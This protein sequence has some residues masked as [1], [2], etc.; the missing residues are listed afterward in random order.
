[1]TRAT[2]ASPSSSSTTLP[3]AEP[4]AAGHRRRAK[5]RRCPSPA[6]AI[7]AASDRAPWH[8]IGAPALDVGQGP[9]SADYGEQADQTV[10]ITIGMGRLE[11]HKPQATDRLY[12]RPWVVYGR[13]CKLA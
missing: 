5:I 7:I 3:R 6:V 4:E 10:G 9:R 2:A 13:F 1:M 8:G 12:Q 11:A